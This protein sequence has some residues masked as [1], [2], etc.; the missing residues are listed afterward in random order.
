MPAEAEVTGLLAL[1]L[2]IEAR[3]ARAS[4]PRAATSCCSP[5]RTAPNGIAS[6]VAEGHELVRDCLRRDQPGPY[7]I[8]AAINAV[9]TDAATAAQT[10][11]QQILQLYD[12]LMVHGTQPGRRAQP[13]R[14]GRRGARTRCRRWRSPTDR[15][16]TATTCCT[17]SARSSWSGSADAPTRLPSTPPQCSSPAQDAQRRFLQ[18]RR[19]DL[20]PPAERGSL[21][22][23]LS[24]TSLACIRRMPRSHRSRSSARRRS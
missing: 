4:A 7:Q 22:A 14:R 20:A 12:Q 2:L 5:T 13:G 16:S 17:R 24:A 6:L 9:H 18:R 8:Q 10:D 1:M 21:T 23:Q 15:R 11:W 19:D 3:R